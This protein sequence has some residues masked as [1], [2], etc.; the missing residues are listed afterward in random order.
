MTGDFSESSKSDVR[1]TTEVV[2][3]KI[4]GLLKHY[5]LRNTSSILI[6]VTKH[7]PDH[8]PKTPTLVHFV[9]LPRDAK[10]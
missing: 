4:I 9:P 8:S 10:Q 7:T 3:D 6:P 1:F 5:Q 2:L